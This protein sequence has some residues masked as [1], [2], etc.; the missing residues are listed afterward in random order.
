MTAA[1]DLRSLLTSDWQPA[2]E[3]QSRMAV[4]GHSVNETRTARRHLGVTKEAGG[5]GFRDGHW[6]WRL[7][8]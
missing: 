4:A 7:P 2:T 1:D 5:V 3:V 6:R 8:V